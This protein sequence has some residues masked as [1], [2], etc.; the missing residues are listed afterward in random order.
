MTA[1]GRGD[2]RTAAATLTAVIGWGGY[3]TGWQSDG[4]DQM[5]AI[6]QGDDRTAAATLTAAIGRW[7]Q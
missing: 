7:Q 4:G 2:D 1:I 5:T 3:W 6:G